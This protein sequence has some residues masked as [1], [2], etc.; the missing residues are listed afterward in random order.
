MTVPEILERDL[1]D[2]LAAQGFAVVAPE[3]VRSA[4]GGA[5]PRSAADAARI[6]REARLFE[7]VLYS[8]LSRWDA[9]RGVSPDYITVKLDLVLIDPA[10]GA[11][12]W[13]ASWPARPVPTDGSGS[14]A[15]AVETAAER[16]V[17]QMTA[18]LRPGDPRATEEAAP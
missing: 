12:R 14:Y 5:V 17:A 16:I 2:R 18:S 1:R 9:S 11:E 6:A 4:S 10:D 8:E 3:T 13:R 7:P 15:V